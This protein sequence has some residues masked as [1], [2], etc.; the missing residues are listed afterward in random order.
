MLRSQIIA[1][2]VSLLLAVFLFR[3]PKVI[4]NQTNKNKLSDKNSV[5]EV[6]PTTKTPQKAVSEIEFSKIQILRK[7]LA[8]TLDVKKRYNFADSLAQIFS[9]LERFDSASKYTELFVNFKPNLSSY[10]KAADLYFKAYD[11]Q[12]EVEAIS[13][14]ASKSQK[15]YQKVLEIDAENLEAKC[16]LAMTYTTS[17][18]PMQAIAL[19]REV[20]QKE[21]KNELA[22]FDLGLLSIQSGQFDKALNRF[23]QLT[24][25][26]NNNWKAQFFLGIAFLETGKKTDAIRKFELV[27]KNAK[28]PA[29]VAQAKQQLAE[30]N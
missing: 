1:V 6:L 9:R 5:S 26:N 19:L 20:L 11:L 15:Y 17:T 24:E 28:D 18:N 23:Q 3:L 14:F 13:F 8:S 22:L 7:K 21:P 4:I 29:L 27:A 25:I 10:Q 16:N 12:T 30:T 2:F